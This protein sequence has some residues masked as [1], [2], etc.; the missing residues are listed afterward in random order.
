MGGGGGIG[1]FIEDAYDQM[2]DN[3]GDAEDSGLVDSAL[4]YLASPLIA[5]DL[6]G[7]SA[8]SGEDPSNYL[9]APGQFL[10][11][12]DE[13]LADDRNIMEL[14]SFNAAL[15]AGAAGGALIGPAAVAGSSPFYAGAVAAP[16]LAGGLAAGAATQALGN[17]ATTRPYDEAVAAA[18][19]EARKQAQDAQ[20]AARSRAQAILAL[21]KDPT[22]D[23]IQQQRRARARR[24]TILT[25]PGQNLGSTGQG[26]SLLGL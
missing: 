22:V 17:A 21:P 2:S 4:A 9:A 15:M 13:Y 26:K 5:Q 8:A 1:G 3:L 20:D 6:A 14:G 7:S 12:P 19:D 18:Q 25:T 16:A 23:E 24:G 10:T 11:N